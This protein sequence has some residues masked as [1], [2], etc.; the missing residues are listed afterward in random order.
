MTPIPKINQFNR[1]GLGHC[2]SPVGL[3]L[4]LCPDT[5][6]Q[7]GV[8]SFPGSFP[9]CHGEKHP[10]HKSGRDLDPDKL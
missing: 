8:Y 10:N 9:S 2:S 6:C 3:S 1:G 4:R 7:L 5:A